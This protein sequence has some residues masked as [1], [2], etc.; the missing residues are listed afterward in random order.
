MMFHTTEILSRGAAELG[1]TLSSRQMKQFGT[2]HAELAAWNQRVNLTAITEHR[3]VQ[4]RHFLDSLTVL[5]ALPGELPSTFRLV[6]IGTG[7]G[8]P[9]LPLK[10]VLPDIHL[11]LVE[12]A[13]KKAQ[14]LEHLVEALGLCGVEVLTGRAEQLAHRD[15][16]RE[17]FDLAV[18]RGL[19]RLPTLL[20][21][22]LPFCRVGGR[23]ALLKHGG[24]EQE[25]AGA[26]RALDV[27]GGRL[28]RTY[29]VQVTGLTDNRVVVAV[30]KVRSTPPGYPRRPGMP[31]KRP[32]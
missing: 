14:F 8:F 3:Q 31:G 5:L 23:V 19:A 16:L 15:D 29:P 13:A 26:A 12:S 6:D 4:V 22:T 11:F 30:D 10:L 18:S 17:S 32:L 25:L 21:Y 28:D 24:I 27:L 20:E 1:L 9:G 7:A 2:Y